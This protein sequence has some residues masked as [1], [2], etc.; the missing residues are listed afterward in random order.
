MSL[1]ETVET[2]LHPIQGVKAKGTGGKAG[3]AQRPE[4]TWSMVE[5][6]SV[7]H[8][9]RLQKELLRRTRIEQPG[10]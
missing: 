10:R 2:G 8:E 3:M 4:R 6:G 1:M 7:A 9:R 5:F